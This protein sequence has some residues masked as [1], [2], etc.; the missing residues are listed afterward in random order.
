VH[1][2]LTSIKSEIE[3]FTKEKD[4]YKGLKLTPTAIDNAPL[5]AGAMLYYS[6]Y[7]FDEYE[8]QMGKLNPANNHYSGDSTACGSSCR[9]DSHDSSCSGDGGG[10]SCGSSCG[11]GCGSS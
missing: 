5:L 11:G 3:R 10:S 1:T 6:Y 9:N 8:S 4:P 7:H 2:L